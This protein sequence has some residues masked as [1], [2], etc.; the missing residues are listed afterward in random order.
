MSHQV[1][2]ALEPSVCSS[3]DLT[4]TV[5]GADS[6]VLVQGTLVT[7]T[8]IFKTTPVILS[9]GELTNKDGIVVITSPGEAR[10]QIDI[11][12]DGFN[13]FNGSSQVYCHH[14]CYACNASISAFLSQE[15]CRKDVTLTVTVTDNQQTGINNAEISIHLVSSLSGVASTVLTPSIFTNT[16]GVV[17]SPLYEAGDYLITVKTPKFQPYTKTVTVDNSTTCTKLN[18]PVPVTL[19]PEDPLPHCN[20]SVNIVVKENRTGLVLPGALVKDLS[21]FLY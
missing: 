4:V 6:K 19:K 21:W 8:N 5:R 18:I 17:S 13:F 2:V 20:N 12:K 15:F 9:N 11:V 1:D 10:L 16:N 3:T 14:P 7:V